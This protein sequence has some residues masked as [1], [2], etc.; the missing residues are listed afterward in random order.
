MLNR[1]HVITAPALLLAGA[2]AT[3]ARALTVHKTA[4][5]ECCE[6]WISAMSDEGFS[7]KV[8]VH[9]DISPIWRARG[10][11]DELSSC[12]LGEIGGYLTVGHVPPADV[13]RLLRERPQAI[14]LSVP[15]MPFGSPGMEQPD[16]RTEP[17]NTLL[18]LPGGRSEVY[19]RYA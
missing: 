6:G 3:P 10:V 16:G 8:I 14:G 9:D 12:H 5:C 18:L 13:K 17:Y 1:R 19:A 15:A 7:A 4:S 2:C 11:P